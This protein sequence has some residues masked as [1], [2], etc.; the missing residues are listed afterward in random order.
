MAGISF[1]SILLGTLILGLVLL[2]LLKPQEVYKYFERK[3]YQY[4]VTL[5]LYMLTP[6]ERFV[7]S[8]YDSYTPAPGIYY[9]PLA[10][11]HVLP[12]V[13]PRRY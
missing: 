7:F 5:A 12:Q 11:S 9:V 8:E 1:G 3:R 2:A 4:D 6:K 10:S 13:D